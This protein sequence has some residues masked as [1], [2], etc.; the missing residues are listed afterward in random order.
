MR[1]YETLYIVNPNYEENRLQDIIGEISKEIEKNK[2][3]VINHRVWGKKRLA[4]SVSKHKYGT[5]ILLQFETAEPKPLPDFETYL[6]LNKNIL[7]SQT[8]RLDNKPEVYL[9]EIR[10][11]DKLEPNDSPPAI[12]SETS[13]EAVSDDNA[14]SEPES[15]AEIE[16]SNEPENVEEIEVPETE[17]ENNLET[18]PQIEEKEEA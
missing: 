16:K 12:T 7:R 9:E 11:D 18:V 6:K 14:N 15:E 10:K 8:V 17:S 1:Y 3:S 2:F 4:F 5:Y 13:D